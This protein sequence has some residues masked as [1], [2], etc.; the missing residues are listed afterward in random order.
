M[1]F[2]LYGVS[3][4]CRIYKK[5]ELKIILSR[6]MCPYAQEDGESGCQTVLAY[7]INIVELGDIL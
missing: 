2:D 7:L 4:L 6:I 1:N 3:Q 5:Y